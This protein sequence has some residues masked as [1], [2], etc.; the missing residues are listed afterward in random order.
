MKGVGV[1]NGQEVNVPSAKGVQ[2]LPQLVLFRLVVV[3]EDGRGVD[4][5]QVA[6]PVGAG[7]GKDHTAARVHLKMADAQG[8]VGDQITVLKVRS[9]STQQFEK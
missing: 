8:P 1:G 3:G 7:V 5:G 6:G 2:L 9:Q 4:V